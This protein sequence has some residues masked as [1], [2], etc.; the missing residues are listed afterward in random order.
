MDFYQ[1]LSDS[2]KTIPNREIPIKMGDLNARICKTDVDEHLRHVVER[3]GIGERNNRELLL[4]F[5]IENNLSAANII[6]FKQETF[7][8]VEI[9]GWKKQKKNPKN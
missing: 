8:Y 6:N 2:V 3:Y 1:Q 5:C 7:I 9:T 4:E